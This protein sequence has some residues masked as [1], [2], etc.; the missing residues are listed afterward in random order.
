MRVGQRY[1]YSS[2]TGTLPTELGELTRLY[3]I[4]RRAAAGNGLVGAVRVST[5]GHERRGEIGLLVGAVGA[6]AGAE[7]VGCAWGGGS[8]GSLGR[9]ARGA[10]VRGQ[11]QGRGDEAEMMALWYLYYNSLTGTLPTELGELTSLQ[12]M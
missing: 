5:L 10:A 12:S 7:E 11:E 4:G 2:L 6:A 8:P 3:Y 9:A 1:L